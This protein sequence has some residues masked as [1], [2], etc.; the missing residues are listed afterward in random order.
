MSQ[1]ALSGPIHAVPVVD[2][3]EKLIR[4]NKQLQECLRESR[5][6]A[7]RLLQTVDKVF[8]RLRPL[9]QVL[10]AIFEGTVETV[11]SPT[12]SSGAP[13]PHN[14]DA[15][16]AWKQ[17]LPDSCAK[18]IDALLVQ[19]LTATQMVTVCRLAYPTITAALRILERNGLT[20]KEGRLVRLKKL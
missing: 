2:E 9:H 5:D 14:R 12:Q 1:P 3:S 19:P 11:S 17:Q 8:A 16:Q 18:V 13:M 15:W 6:E 20:Q 7:E 10:T 4:E